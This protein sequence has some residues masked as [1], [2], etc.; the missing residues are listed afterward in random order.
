[1]RLNK[2]MCHLIYIF[3]YIG[4]TLYP[5]AI[6]PLNHMSVGRRFLELSPYWTNDLKIEYYIFRK[7]VL[8]SLRFKK[9]FHITPR[10]FVS[11]TFAQSLRNGA[12]NFA[13]FTYNFVQFCA[14]VIS[15]KIVLYHICTTL[16]CAIPCAQFR[17]FAILIHVMICFLGN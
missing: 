15:R 6:A 8:K 9:I 11:K 3:L 10:L 2:I 1:M 14:K 4:C 16:F 12:P 17:F 5:L 7:S 13:T